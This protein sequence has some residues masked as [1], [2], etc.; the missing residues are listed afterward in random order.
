MK[1]FLK[2]SGHVLKWVGVILFILSIVLFPLLT[3]I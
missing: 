2:K 3:I 1:K